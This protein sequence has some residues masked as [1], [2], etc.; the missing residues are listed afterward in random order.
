MSLVV[1]SFY[2]MSFS[3]SRQLIAH[4]RV[5]AKFTNPRSLYLEGSLS[6]LYNQV[7]LNGYG[8][9]WVLVTDTIYSV[10]NNPL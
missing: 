1:L 7:K 8:F 6:E 9:I 2:W 5:F 3:S 4:L 10:Y